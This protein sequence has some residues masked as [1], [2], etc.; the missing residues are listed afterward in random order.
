MVG[1]AGRKYCREHTGNTGGMYG[2]NVAAW[3]KSNFYSYTL[4]L[5]LQKIAEKE[6]KYKSHWAILNCKGVKGWNG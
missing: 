2:T 6:R 3:L 1:L 5:C 4:Y